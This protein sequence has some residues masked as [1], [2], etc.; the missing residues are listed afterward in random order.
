MLKLLKSEVPAS[1]KIELLTTSA[2]LDYASS[3]TNKTY[4]TKYGFLHV[5]KLTT[6]LVSQAK[7]LPLQ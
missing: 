2:C 1:V 5:Y 3:E 7:S 6:Y 4:V